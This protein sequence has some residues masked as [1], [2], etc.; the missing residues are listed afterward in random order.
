[1]QIDAGAAIAARMARDCREMAA[2]DAAARE[3]Y[4][5]VRYSEA[6]S[7]YAHH[8]APLSEAETIKVGD[9]VQV[10]IRHC[11]V[12]PVAVED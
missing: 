5:L 12:P 2:P 9:R 11:D 1:M 6:P 8:V 3:R 7:R 10:N 4:A